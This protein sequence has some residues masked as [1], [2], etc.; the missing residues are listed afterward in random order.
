MAMKEQKP[1]GYELAAMAGAAFERQLIIKSLNLEIE[2][3]K[4]LNEKKSYVNGMQHALL[5]IQ[6]RSK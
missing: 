4:D 5:L 1:E 2:A 6:E 3:A